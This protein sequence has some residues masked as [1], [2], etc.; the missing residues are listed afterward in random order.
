LGEKVK[1][2]TPKI[3]ARPPAITINPH[4]AQAIVSWLTCDGRFLVHGINAVGQQ[5][6]R[7]IEVEKIATGERFY[8][9]DRGLRRLLKEP[10]GSLQGLDTSDFEA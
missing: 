4:M 2:L 6:T 8:G 9:S 3:N 7:I 10:G 5:K 1:I